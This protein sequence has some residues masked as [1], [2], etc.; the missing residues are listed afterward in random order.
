MGLVL[1]QRDMTL[2]G[3]GSMAAA[4]MLIELLSELHGVVAFA[5]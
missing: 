1:L 3:A 4:L 5:L 2:E